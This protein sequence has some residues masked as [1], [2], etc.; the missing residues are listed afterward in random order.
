MDDRRVSDSA[1]L[2]VR[3]GRKRKDEARL[4]VGHGG[5]VRPVR[6]RHWALFRRPI[7]RAEDP[8][9]EERED[10]PDSQSSRSVIRLVPCSYDYRTAASSVEERDGA[11]RPDDATLSGL[12]WSEYR[13]TGQHRLGTVF[14]A[15]SWL[16]YIAARGVPSGARRRTVNQIE[17]G[18]FPGPAFTAI[19]F[20]YFLVPLILMVLVPVLLFRLLAH[21]R[22]AREQLVAINA[23]VVRLQLALAERL[24]ERHDDHGG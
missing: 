12:R 15:R 24:G 7:K 3:S 1:K 9:C 10:D 20:L 13:E 22:A 16:R 8:K 6:G 19:S 17:A 11:G 23:N 5:C 4:T 14:E 18:P 21:V 2:P